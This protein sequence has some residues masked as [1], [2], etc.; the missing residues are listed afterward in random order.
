MK[1]VIIGLF[2]L[3]LAA[4]VC[5]AVL[6]A[7]YSSGGESTLTGERVPS[8][9]AVLVAAHDLDALSEV[10]AASVTVRRVARTSAPTDALSDP[11][12]AAGRLL[13]V[14]I[15]EG[16]PLLTGSFVGD[17]SS[18]R[19]AATLQPGFRA[20]NVALSD[21]MGIEPLLTPG[22]VVDVLATIQLRSYDSSGQEP[23]SITLLQDV[24]V[25]AVG[26]RSIVSAPVSTAAAGGTAEASPSRGRPTVTLLVN[27]QQ[28][29]KLKLAMQEG[30][31]SLAV[32]NP[33]DTNY[34]DVPGTAL[35]QLSPIF[36]Y[37]PAPATDESDDESDPPATEP[38]PPP[39]PLPPPP[40]NV[41]SVLQRQWETVILRG[42][43]SETR[44]FA[45]PLVGKD[46]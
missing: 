9:V 5:A 37:R 44:T 15:K 4:A 34:E 31:V 30:S 22:S 41:P 43:V 1:W 20:V 29:E 25:L 24:R 42:G 21:P 14:Q 13:A 6:V 36:A 46:R 38:P 40:L 39:P 17:T 2:G 28:A 18:L 3:G 16:Q 33:K 23:V 10:D 32:R 11:L 19:L 7:S 45:E 12:Q 8:D 27:A 35:A 26:D